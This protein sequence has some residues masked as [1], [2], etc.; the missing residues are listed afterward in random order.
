MITARN[1]S[2][3]VAAVITA[4]GS[5]ATRATS[6]IK[7]S[8]WSVKLTTAK[9]FRLV[10]ADEIRRERVRNK[11]RKQGAEVAGRRSGK[12]NPDRAGPSRLIDRLRNG[13][14]ECAN[15]AGAACTRHRSLS[16]PRD[17]RK[18]QVSTHV[19]GQW[20]TC[21]QHF[22]TPESIH[23]D[24]AAAHDLS[25]GSCRATALALSLTSYLTAI[26]RHH[27]PTN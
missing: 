11:Q 20:F 3:W 8:R 26:P 19:N 5:S 15:Q 27:N 1:Q 16:I 9:S 7:E 2:V 17:W 12:T 4:K 21:V 25:A 18:S 24:N 22:D 6:I 14:E 23:I 13:L 10:Q